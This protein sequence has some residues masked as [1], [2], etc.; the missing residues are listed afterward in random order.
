MKQIILLSAMIL[1]VSLVQAQSAQQKAQHQPLIEASEARTFTDSDTEFTLP[2]RLFKPEHI[3]SGK[4]YPLIIFLHGAG[5]RGADNIS[6]LKN[7][8]VLSLISGKNRE[9]TPTFLI[10]PQCPADKRWCEVSW[11]QKTPHVTPERPS[12]PMA[13][14]LKVFDLLKKEYP[15]DENRI[16]VTGLS[17]GG[18]GTCDFALRRS[19]EIAA[20]AP[21]CGG[22]DDAALAAIEDVPAW[23]FHGD[24][25]PA[26]PVERSRSAVKALKDAGRSVHYTEF[27]GWGHNIWVIAYDT[28]GFSD[29]LFSQKR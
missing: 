11:N 20:Y 26:V 5:E 27:P 28:E 13:A 1:S 3:E 25:D 29:W 24:K 9:Q 22:G 10:A 16:Y 14:L 2:Y 4:K 17:M 7:P 8:Q 19:K 18:Y 15:I 6:Q 21:L 23:F 12:V